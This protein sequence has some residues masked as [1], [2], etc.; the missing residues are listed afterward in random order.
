[1]GSDRDIPPSY[2][3]VE[4]FRKVMMAFA[5]YLVILSAV[6]A[7]AVYKTTETLNTQHTQGVAFVAKQCETSNEARQSLLDLLQFAE[8]RTRNTPVSPGFTQ[9]QKNNGIKFYNE[10]ESRIHIITCPSTQ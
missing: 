6:L 8:N 2:V 10:A 4:V 1:M 3:T 9:D 7:Y 5:I